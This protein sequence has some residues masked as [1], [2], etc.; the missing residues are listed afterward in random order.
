MQDILLVGCGIWGQ[1][2]LHELVVENCRVAV[3][4]EDQEI[5]TIALKI[6]ATTFYEK[7]PSAMDY[8][9]IV[10]ATPSSHHR[11]ILEELVVFRIPIFI[12]KP[13]CTSYADA[14]IL[15]DLPFEH[16]YVMHVWMYHPGV[17]GLARLAEEGQIGDLLSIKSI[18]A[19]WTSPRKDTDSIW[20]LSPH[21]LTIAKTILGY[22]PEP[23]A[24]AI[25][26]HQGI[27]RGMTAILG[28]RP[29]CHF[30]VSNR[31]E[32]KLR[33]IRI[34]G[35]DGVAMLERE[36]SKSI[37]LFKGDHNTEWDQV[38]RIRIDL[39][40]YSAL[41]A[42]IKEF[43]SF[44]KGGSPPRSDIKE[45]VEVIRIIDHIIQIAHHGKG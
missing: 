17:L 25:E 13:L 11:E 30:E 34:H 36:S 7:L 15:N 10:V 2:I 33:E 1:K 31:Y 12:E 20:N 41:Q 43:L 29:F 14:R 37:Q 40:E 4:D 28:D 35:T 38:E 3:V 26:Y 39:P 19:N 22:F 21:D 23:K 32:R 27:A 5:K 9:G 44:L 6:G 8:D 24:A 42:E 18:R 16:I 45:G